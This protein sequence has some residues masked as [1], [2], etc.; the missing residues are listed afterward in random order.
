MEEGAKLWATV[1][2]VAPFP[3]NSKIYIDDFTIEKQPK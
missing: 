3:K 2:F 1:Y